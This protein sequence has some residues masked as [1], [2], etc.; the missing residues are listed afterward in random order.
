MDQLKQQILSNL[1]IVDEISAYVKLNK[2]GTN[3]KGLCCFHEEKT[4]SFVVSPSKSLYHCFGCGAGGDVFNF[5]MRIK[6][7]TFKEVLEYYC[8]K[9]G[10]SYR[11]NTKYAKL[12]EINSTICEYFQGLLTQDCIDY[13]K[14]RCIIEHTIKQYKLGYC[15]SNISNLTN[16]ALNNNISLNDL[17]DANIVALY[18]RKPYNVF[19]YRYIIPLFDKS[20][21]ILGF[22]G[23][24]SMKSENKFLNTIDTVLYKKKEF[25]FGL[26]GSFSSI[27]EHNEAIVVE[28]Y[29]DQIIL[30]QNNIK[31]SVALCGTSI[32][33]NQAIKLKSL[34]SNI[35]LCL[36]G[37]KAGKLATIKAAQTL[38]RNNV[39]VKII[40]LNCDPD[41]YIKEHGRSNFLSL[42]KIDFVDY[43][44]DSKLDKKNKFDIFKSIVDF[45]DPTT[46]SEALNKI[47]FSLGFLKTDLRS[48]FVNIGISENK[49]SEEDSFIRLLVN[50][51]S[52]ISKVKE[53]IFLSDTNKK[54]F[55]ILSNNTEVDVETKRR[56]D[57]MLVIGYE[58]N[59]IEFDFEYK[60]KRL[61]ELYN[62]KLKQ[63]LLIKLKDNSLTSKDKSEIITKLNRL[64]YDK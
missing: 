64:L 19:A 16:Y 11:C 49:E 31:N 43:L 62:T 9:L 13:F 21:A 1:D 10:I 35:V 47:E 55:S 52:F 51:Q 18:N 34:C 8:K 28:G 2:N 45:L 37:D 63:D 14:S 61:S 44:I 27:K 23:R 60:L 24:T 30:N 6:N 56:I 46:K 59:N 5:M 38:I 48:T 12:Y 15:D 57:G 36:D 29:F 54:L 25:I 39:G 32:T 17:I 26:N 33:D 3:Y 41:E 50:N 53:N 42:P 4:P 22:V 7:F 20:N 58:S 40:D